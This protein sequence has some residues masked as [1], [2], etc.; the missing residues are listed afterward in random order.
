VV[1][2]PL[3]AFVMQLVENHDEA[4]DGR[5]G[6][7]VRLRRERGHREVVRRYAEMADV[8]RRAAHRAV[9][10]LHRQLRMLD[11]RVEGV[12]GR[13]RLEPAALALVRRS[14]GVRDD[15]LVEAAEVTYGQIEQLRRRVPLAWSWKRSRG[16]V[17]ADSELHALEAQLDLLETEHAA[18]WTRWA[19]Y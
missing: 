8:D 5:A 17:P 13:D 19:A 4:V 2:S 3:D 14:L 12:L 11:D 6:L 15:A 7:L 18:I 1:E 10:R 16:I 9:G